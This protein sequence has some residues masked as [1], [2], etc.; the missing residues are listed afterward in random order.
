MKRTILSL[1]CC[2]GFSAAAIGVPMAA[3]AATAATSGT[4][5]V[6]SYGNGNGSSPIVLT[7][8]IGDSGKAVDVNANGTPNPNGNYVKFELKQGTI[9]TNTTKI[10]SA[11]NKANPMVNANNCSAE[12]TI[13]LSGLPIVSGTGAYKG[14][15]GSV[16]SLTVTYAF[17][18]PKFASGAKKGTCN[19]SN[20][21]NPIATMAIYSGSGTVT[22]PAG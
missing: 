4:F 3:M 14:I 11:F 10:N 2:L 12:I 5:H 6:Y 18:L 21:A 22:V 19:E 7:G 8:A 9:L 13:N 16:T 1:L 17:I 15:M 20:S